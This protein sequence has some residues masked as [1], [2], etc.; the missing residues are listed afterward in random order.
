MSHRNPGVEHGWPVSLTDEALEALSPWLDADSLRPVYQGDA[1]RAAML[2]NA[3]CW[4]AAYPELLALTV[5]CFEEDDIP[6]GEAV[7]FLAD[8]RGEPAPEPQPAPA[9]ETT[10]TALLPPDAPQAKGGQSVSPVSVQ[11]ACTGH[12][13]EGF[14]H[15]EESRPGE[16]RDCGLCGASFRV[17]Y[18]HARVHR[19]CSAPCRSKARH[20][21]KRTDKALVEVNASTQDP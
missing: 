10:E 19:F 8:L 3:R 2:L 7:S 1:D 18:R 4:S 9:Q 15:T 20:L 13:G 17:N 16:T 5:R 11:E 6:P 14:G 21:R 12:P